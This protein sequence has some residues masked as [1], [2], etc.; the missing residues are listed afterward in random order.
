MR[1]VRKEVV[2]CNGKGFLFIGLCLFGFVLHGADKSFELE[3]L[4]VFKTGAEYEEYKRSHP[5]VFGIGREGEG[6]IRLEGD[7][8]RFYDAEGNL[9]CERRVYRG[10]EIFEGESKY[11]VKERFKVYS[12]I[13][14]SPRGDLV[15]DERWKTLL[16]EGLDS[17]P[18]RIIIYNERGEITGEIDPTSGRE[19]LFPYI[20][21]AS[22]YIICIG[23]WELDV[24]RTI[25]I[26]NY[27]G[28][29][30][31]T[32]NFEIGDKKSS[33]IYDA[34]VK[35]A[36]S[37][38]KRYAVVGISNNS[39]T[40]ILLIDEKAN[41]LWRRIIEGEMYGS[42]GLSIS[43]FGEYMA[44]N[45]VNSYNDIFKFKLIVFNK[46]GKEIFTKQT[47][48]EY[49]TFIDNTRILAYIEE[50]ESIALLDVKDG[51]VLYKE[52]I[53]KVESGYG[54]QIKVEKGLIGI[55]SHPN[56]EEAVILQHEFRND[57]PVYIFQWKA[58]D[59]LY[60]TRR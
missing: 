52:K 6:R 36:F 46:N 17:Y 47:Y 20:L 22:R 15:L 24:D 32:L 21:P 13:Q 9:I 25:Y 30:I 48:G 42:N 40:E 43:A 16:P 14:I 8:L 57:C 1:K 29:L 51:K 18:Y 55:G 28:E 2:M 37:N 19:F 12:H 45:N 54:I 33:I 35:I 41:V 59:E 5:E 44:I 49:L 27:K 26:Y 60:I 31:K 3:L 39:F 11:G 34:S 38:D 7:R 53:E 4:K 10:K 58:S 56:W 50:N 23:E